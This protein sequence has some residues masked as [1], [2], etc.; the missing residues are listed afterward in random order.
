MPFRIESLSFSLPFGVGEI[1]VQRTEAQMRA[2]WALYVELATR[3]STQ[4]LPAGQGSCR[5]A[6]DSLYSLFEAT[7][8]TLKE[9]GPYAVEGAQSV[10][11]LAIRV[12]NE[13]IRPFLAK[14][15]DR[16]GAFEDEQILEHYRE[17]GG[18]SEPVIDEGAWP[19][20]TAFDAELA[21]LRKGIAQY[22]DAL[23]EIAGVKD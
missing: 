21:A 12:L 7:R 9:A 20:R 11:P 5:E 22:V 1:T 10:G 3:V 4:P 13:G 2:A 18:D 6:L 19:D 14:W 15:H 8:T 23:G 16:L 17:Y